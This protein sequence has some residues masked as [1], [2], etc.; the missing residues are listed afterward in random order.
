MQL[1]ESANN[2]KYI[3]EVISFLEDIHNTANSYKLD[4][5][6]HNSTLEKKYLKQ[7]HDLQFISARKNLKEK[8][9]KLQKETPVVYYFE[10]FINMFSVQSSKKMSNLDK[11]DK[12]YNSLDYNDLY[13][14]NKIENSFIKIEF[15]SLKSYC[16]T[17]SETVEKLI[18]DYEEFPYYSQKFQLSTK[19][20]FQLVDLK[21][22]YLKE[23]KN[24]A[25][26]NCQ[27]KFKSYLEKTIKAF[28]SKTTNLK[29]KSIFDLYFYEGE[30]LVR[31]FHVD[32]IE[33][34]K[35]TI[36]EKKIIHDFFLER[37]RKDLNDSNP[38]NYSILSGFNNKSTKEI[39]KSLNKNFLLFEEHHAFSNF[40]YYF[41][42][43]PDSHEQLKEI[44]LEM[45][46]KNLIPSHIEQS[47][48]KG[49]REF[50]E[51]YRRIIENYNLHK[52]LIEE[53]PEN[54]PLVKKKVI[55]V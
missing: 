35:K 45:K 6:T 52:D 22:D 14:E 10:K 20:L 39:I 12:F 40:D 41:G 49:D 26:K 23:T 13:I 21:S 53:L 15:V 11:L 33:K 17:F 38:L 36:E 4:E 37:Y 16:K 7:L 19:D 9:K 44:I 43:Y 24:F 34:I 1:Q 5:K 28:T 48:V 18:S 42:Y 2:L 46:K 32:N 30:S 29:Q 50:H 51:F 47:I 31:G 27:E 54:K 3:K 55:K 8:E 25:I